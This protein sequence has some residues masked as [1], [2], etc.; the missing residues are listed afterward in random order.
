MGA[1]GCVA[2]HG[3]VLAGRISRDILREHILG[4]SPS[5]PGVVTL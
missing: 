4:R 1:E 5:S 3:W 2:N